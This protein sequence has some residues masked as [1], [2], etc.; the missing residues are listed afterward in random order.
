MK[1]KAEEQLREAERKV[2]KWLQVGLCTFN[3]ALCSQPQGLEL[4]EEVL[5]EAQA[6]EE[7]SDKVSF[8]CLLVVHFGILF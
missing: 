5:H 8:G 1:A 3:L 2:C 4:Q 6:S 7:V